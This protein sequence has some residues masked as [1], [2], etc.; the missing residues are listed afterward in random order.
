MV[1]GIKKNEE[2]ENKGTKI[3]YWVAK[4]GLTEKMT[5]VL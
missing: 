4:N 1:V 5:F 3:L 2:K